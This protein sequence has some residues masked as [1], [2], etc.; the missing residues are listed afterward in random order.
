[1]AA[2]PEVWKT[3]SHAA[4]QV[5]WSLLGALVGL[6][7]AVGLR[8]FE[9]SGIANNAAGFLLGLFILTLSAAMLLAARKQV[10]CVDPTARRIV[11]EDVGWYGRRTRPLAF[12]E[13]AEFYVDEFVDGEDGNTCYFV[14]AHL[15]TGT[16]VSLFLGH[17]EGRFDRDA[18]QTRC[19]RLAAYVAA[20]DGLSNSAVRV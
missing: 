18:M 5:G 19:R 4:R 12:D 10:I 16:R 14:V 8:H 20:V 6:A 1:M 11:V 13:I 9:R 17:F 3:E 7:L 2:N 15:K